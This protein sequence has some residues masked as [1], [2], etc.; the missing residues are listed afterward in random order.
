MAAKLKIDKAAWTALPKEAQ[1]HY[2]AN[3]DGYALDVEGGVSVSKLQADMK[4]ARDGRIAALQ[5]RDQLRTRFDGVDP[6][7]YKSQR[8]RIA[9]LEAKGVDKPSDVD[10]RIAAVET[11]FQAKLDAEVVK[12]EAAEERATARER[13]S[14][15]SS[16][17]VEAGVRPGAVRMLRSVIGEIKADDAGALSIGDKPLNDAV[18]AMKADHGYL[19]VEARGGGTKPGD[20]PGGEK[21]PADMTNEELVEWSAKQDAITQ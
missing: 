1:A 9:A 4:A 6:D 18:L 5:E 13:D 14:A 7:V 11:S 10:A 8:E 2:K 20:K 16:A 12:R 21:D 3:G 19:F 15:F 17:A